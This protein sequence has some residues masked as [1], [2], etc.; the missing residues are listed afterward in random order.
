MYL[1]PFY[2]FDFSSPEYLLSSQKLMMM[3]S[4]NIAMWI[5]WGTVFLR[6]RASGKSGREKGWGTHA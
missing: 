4:R 1:K 6:L 2:I 3:K 5:S